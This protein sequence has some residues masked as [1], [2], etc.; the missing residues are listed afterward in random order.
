[1]CVCSNV[2]L[3]PLHINLEARRHI[4]AGHHQGHLAAQEVLRDKPFK[5]TTIYHNSRHSTG[6]LCEL[7][8]II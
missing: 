4:T 8:L 1:M 5:I 3:K 7:T 2:A 6:K